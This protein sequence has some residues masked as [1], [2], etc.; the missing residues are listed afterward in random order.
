MIPCDV[1]VV[2]VCGTL[3][4]DDTTAGLLAYHF[5]RTPERPWRG[6]LLLALTARRSP[7][8]ICFAVLE[9]LSGRHVL[10]HVLVGLLKGDSLD[11]LNASAKEYA[12]H[13]LDQRRV[14][15][16]WDRLAEPL[17]SGRV[18]LASAS[19]EPVVAA[20]A[21][22]LGARHV[23][24]SLA[25]HHGVLTGAYT[26][27]LTGCKESALT[28]KYGANVLSG[29]V[30]V[31]SDNLSDRPLLEKAAQACVVLHKPAHRVRWSGLAAH[32]LLVDA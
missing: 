29:Q 28:V 4:R 19:L 20:L 1:Y 5:K 32:F 31:I 9:K 21:A 14:S 10:K 15:N 18:V 8:R 17:E 25:A 16:V 30:C 2:D 23:A 26:H 12:R 3:V 11:A 7:L 22:A 27:D 13:L 6:A 24:S